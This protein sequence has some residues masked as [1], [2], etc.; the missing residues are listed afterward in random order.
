MRMRLAGPEDADA[1][2]RLINRAFQV[3]KF[4]IDTD[5]IALP[6]VEEHLGSGEF[7]VLEDADKLMACVY[8]RRNG[9]RG[10]FGLLS[11]DPLLQRG[12]LGKR[13]IAAAEDRCR[14]QGCRVMDLQIV[15]LRE[16]LPAYYRGLG[17]TESGTAEFPTDVATKTPCH[18]VRMSKPL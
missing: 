6:E 14:A 17:Y 12:G 7:M 4:F 1:L 13:M 16:E 10:Y 2:M 15:N 5:R 11:V 9:E 8:I 18:F 3:E